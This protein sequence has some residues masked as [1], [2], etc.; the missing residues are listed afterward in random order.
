MKLNV[1]K[2]NSIAASFEASGYIVRIPTNTGEL[3]HM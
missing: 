2:D 3:N 1:Y